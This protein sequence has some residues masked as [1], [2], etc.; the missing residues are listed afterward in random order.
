LLNYGNLNEVL[1]R[2]KISSTREG[3][4]QGKEPN[5]ANKKN[6]INSKKG[7]GRQLV[8]RTWI[9]KQSEVK[10]PNRGLGRL[11]KKN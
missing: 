9:L 1:P 3:K 7:D 5:I 6:D 2:R 10:Q 8:M 4:A 11:K